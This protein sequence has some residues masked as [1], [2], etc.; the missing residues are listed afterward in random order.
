MATGKGPQTSVL[1]GGV[2]DREPKPGDGKGVGIQERGVLM[3]T[4][5]PADAR[6]FEDVHALQRPSLGHA[7]IV[8][9]AHQVGRVTERR[10]D[11]VEV[12]H[13]VADL[14]DRK[15]LRLAKLSIVV[16]GLFF[17]K[18]PHA[19]ARVEKLVVGDPGLFVGAE[20]S[21]LSARLPLLHHFDRPLLQVVAG[22]LA[23]EILDDDKAVS[24]KG[25]N[26]RARQCRH[27]WSVASVVVFRL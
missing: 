17:E 6:L 9:D 24:L 8:G 2:F 12:V 14:V 23:D 1:K 3:A 19:V 18:A 11:R 4:H 22:G 13:G 25:C 5:F 21:P 10:E 15:F 7:Q 27:R 26:L 20:R 16:E